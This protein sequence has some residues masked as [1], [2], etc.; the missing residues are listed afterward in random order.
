MEKRTNVSNCESSTE[1][2][3]HNKTTFSCHVAEHLK[4]ALELI[5]SKHVLLPLIKKKWISAIYWMISYL[6]CN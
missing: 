6:C 1:E 2:E 3:E 4:F 5:E